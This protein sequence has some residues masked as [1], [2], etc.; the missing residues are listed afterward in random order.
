MFIRQTDPQFHDCISQ[1][2]LYFMQDI[3][4]GHENVQSRSTFNK[5][6]NSSSRFSFMVFSICDFMTFLS[7][8]LFFYY[9][10]AASKILEWVLIIYYTWVDCFFF[11]LYFW[12]IFILIF[13][14]GKY[15]YGYIRR[16]F[17][18]I[19]NNWL[20]LG[21]MNKYNM[22]VKAYMQYGGINMG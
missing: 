16:K 13:S 14:F 11:F 9:V 10:N 18:W 5:R 3:E 4:N 17:L 22:D 6:Y 7:L 8:F 12:I 1:K 20:N 19:V 2:T 15:T 21:S